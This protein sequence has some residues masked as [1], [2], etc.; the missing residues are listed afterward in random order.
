MAAFASTI[1]ILLF[2]HY[3][4]SYC[5]LSTG[6]TQAAALFIFGDSI[7]DCGNND[8][9]PNSTATADYLPYGMDFY[10]V[11]GRFS[12][13]RNLADC[14]AEQLG[15]ELLIACS[16]DP[17][18]TG[19]RILNGVN[20]ASAGSGVLDAT[21]GGVAVTPL[22][23]QVQFFQDKTLPDLESQ[24]EGNLSSFLA[25][26]LFL[27]NTGGNDLFEQCFETGESCDVPAFCD[28]LV[29]EI[30]RTFEWLYS[31]GA[32]KF[33]ILSTESSG[34]TPFVRSSNNG[35]CGELVDSGSRIYN[36][37]L[38]ASTDRLAK[39]LPGSHFVFVS[40][41][42]VINSLMDDPTTYGFTSVTEACCE[43][44]T[45]KSGCLENGWTCPD[46]SKYLYWD[47]G[48]PTDRSNTI[49]AS[50]VYDSNDTSISYPFSIKELA[51]INSTMAAGSGLFIRPW[52]TITNDKD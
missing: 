2:L 19:S 23:H 1:V 21:T 16:R 42:D 7:V 17:N 29:S 15:F 28:I 6:E 50:K 41:Y 30:S 5:L 13:A 36:Y 40:V 3:F 48:H 24:L 27:F 12:N 32:R 34:C 14:I 9:L 10:A 45:G 8:Y 47:G 49:L 25:Q 4:S 20:Y 52:S 26:S 35:T 22:S 46:R 18:S 39:S 51:A 31:M 43:L 33:I 11:T 44:P 38:N 37:Q